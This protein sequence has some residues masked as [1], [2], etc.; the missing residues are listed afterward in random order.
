M[1]VVLAHAAPSS[2]LWPLIEEAVLA[3]TS[4]AVGPEIPLALLILS[5]APSPTDS[6][7]APMTAVRTIALAYSVGQMMG[8]DTVSEVWC[9]SRWI[10]LPEW[11]ARLDQLLLVRSPL[12]HQL[13]AVGDDQ[14]PVQYVSPS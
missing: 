12:V 11:S 13:I 1:L 7:R 8:W 2:Q 5:L 10:T 14:E 3:V 9:Q 6:T 4:G